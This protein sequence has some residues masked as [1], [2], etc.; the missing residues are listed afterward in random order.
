MI[1]GVILS[2]GLR[3]LEKKMCM[4]EYV[5][6]F[7]LDEYILNFS[8]QWEYFIGKY[9]LFFKKFQWKILYRHKYQ[10]SRSN[11]EIILKKWSYLSIL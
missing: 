2:H 4:G 6:L 1:H 8:K 11:F 7:L 9:F 10:D 3:A 5:M